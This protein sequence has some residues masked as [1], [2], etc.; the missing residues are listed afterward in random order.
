MRVTHAHGILIDVDARFVDAAE[1]E[2]VHQVVVHLF[3]VYFHTQLVGIEWSET[4]GETLL[5]EVVAHVQLVLRPYADCDVDRT[6]PIGFRQHFEHHQL[7]LVEGAFAFQRDVHVV[8]D[9]IARYHHSAAAYGFLIHFHHDAVGRNYLQV[10]VL[11]AYPV[12]QY[13]L[14]FVRILAEF[15]LHV[16]QC[17]GVAA[18]GL[19]LC[20]G[21]QGIDALLV[22]GTY[23]NIFVGT[24]Y[25][26][27]TVPRDRQGRRVVGGTLHL[28][29]V[30]VGLQVAEVAGTGVGAEAFRFLVVPQGEGIVIAVGVY[31]R[32]TRFL[33]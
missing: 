9:G 18:Q 29:D 5:N 7:T 12:F 24:F 26:L 14:E 21:I 20:F 28:V 8:G 10:L 27:H 11:A 15:F 16:Y 33:Q 23:R 25:I 31:N 6:L 32:I 30:P 4:V 2:L 1:L 13:V 22:F 17:F 19:F 3:A